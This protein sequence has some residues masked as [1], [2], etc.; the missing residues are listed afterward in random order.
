MCLH[1]LR[2]N[3]QGFSL[4]E[5]IGSGDTGTGNAAYY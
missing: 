5:D 4:I 3:D 2:Q 1:E